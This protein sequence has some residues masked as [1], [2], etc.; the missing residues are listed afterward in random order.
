ML[1]SYFL[2]CLL[3]C[4]Y[5]DVIASDNFQPS[6]GNVTSGDNSG[7][8]EILGHHWKTNKKTSGRLTQELV[9]SRGN[10]FLR[11]KVKNGVIYLN[12]NVPQC[13]AK[14]E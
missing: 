1:I 4:L 5:R 6:A 7:S 8:S 2:L 10:K 3:L 14:V 11:R 12:C 9:D 13:K